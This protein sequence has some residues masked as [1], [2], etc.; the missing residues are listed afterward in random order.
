MPLYRV[1]LAGTGIL[2]AL[3]DSPDPIVGFMAT[4]QVIA[5]TAADAEALAISMVTV[6]WSTGEYADSNKGAAP[7][8]EVEKTW[9]IDWWRRF[10]GRAP[11]GYSFYC[12][13]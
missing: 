9:R 8:L 13:E 6:E 1:R 7:S 2:V 11:S 5:R 4:R 3:D 12:H 10:V